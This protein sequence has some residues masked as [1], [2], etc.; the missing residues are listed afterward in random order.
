MVILIL[1]KINYKNNKRKFIYIGC[2]I[3][4]KKLLSDFKDKNFQLQTYGMI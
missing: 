1:K 2:Q 3:I 4:N